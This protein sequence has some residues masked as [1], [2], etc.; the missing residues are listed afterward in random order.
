[1][2]NYL[3]IFIAL[4]FVF[5]ACSDDFTDLTP[6]GSVTSGN[7]WQT[8]ED[9]LTAANGLYEHWDEQQFIWQGFYVPHCC[10]VMTS[11]RAE[12]ML[13]CSGHQE[14]SGHR[15]G[16]QYGTYL[17]KNVHSDPKG[18]QHSALCTKYEH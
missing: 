14:F 2:K 9:A 13:Q 12:P 15:P 18:Q 6:L 5:S 4:A 16:K 10:H 17:S 1:M 3:K 7:F 11:N 8:E